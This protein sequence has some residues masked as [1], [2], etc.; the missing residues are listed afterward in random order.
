MI[1][2]MTF[3]SV[4]VAKCLY[5]LSLYCNCIWYEIKISSRFYVCDA[6]GGGGGV[7]VCA[8]SGCFLLQYPGMK[9]VF[10]LQFI[11]RWKTFTSHVIGAKPWCGAT[12]ASTNN[13]LC[14]LTF[15]CRWSRIAM[16]LKILNM[17]ADKVSPTLL[18][19]INISITTGEF[20]DG[21]KIAK[22]IPIHKGGAADDPSNY[23]P[24]SIIPVIS[25]IIEKHV[26]KHLFG[27][28]N[29]YQLLHR[30]QSGFRKHHSC[31]TALLNLVDK[32]LS[33]IDK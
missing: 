10:L 17:A 22:L 21:L 25:K 11:S 15:A 18:K 19:I 14:L 16:T 31:N 9:L 3:D 12:S 23:R 29:K 27:F 2:P 6:G 8:R 20:P 26:T 13:V 30:S 24:I 32:W 28:L 7:C 1:N 5:S 4:N 33:A